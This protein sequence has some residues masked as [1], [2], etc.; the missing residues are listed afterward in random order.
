MAAVDIRWLDAM[1]QVSPADVHLS[2]VMPCLDEERTIGSCVEKALAAFRAMNMVGEVVVADNGST[3]RSVEIAHS[4]GARVVKVA[5]KGYGSA[6]AAGIQAAR[7]EYIIMADSD[8][9]Y[10]WSNL[11]PFVDT[12]DVGNDLVVGGLDGSAV[13]IRCL[14]ESNITSRKMTLLM[15]TRRAIE[16]YTRA[17][18]FPINPKN[19]TAEPR[20]LMI[21]SRVVKA[22]KNDVQIN[23]KR[24]SSRQIL[25]PAGG[26]QP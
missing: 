24:P 22:S 16:W 26:T 6:L 12:L 8:G 7:G 23:T 20:G 14:A 2:A 9:S 10:D 5:A 13:L 15:A 4:L 1:A 25:V 18:W 17:G 11:K 3:D 19:T 21:G